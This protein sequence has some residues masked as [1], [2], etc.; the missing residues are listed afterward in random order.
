M[1]RLNNRSPEQL[2]MPV[3][4]NLHFFKYQKPNNKKYETLIKKSVQNMLSNFDDLKD[5]LK[6]SVEAYLFGI[7]HS[8]LR[9]KGKC[10][11]N[12]LLKN[13]SKAKHYTE[14]ISPL[15]EAIKEGNEN[16][17]SLKT[18]LY[19]WITAM[20]CDSQLFVRFDVKPTRFLNDI[21]AETEKQV[22]LSTHIR[23]HL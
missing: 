18:V 22:S 11:A 6:G 19:T 13:L 7:E 5:R 23:S 14:L 1:F 12:E 3:P 17:D 10:R 4:A 20:F 8:F 9:N 21:L 16:S 15:K 2:A